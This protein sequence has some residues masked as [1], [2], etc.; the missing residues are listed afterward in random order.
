L[1]CYAPIKLA[2]IVLL[3]LIFG[4]LLIFPLVSNGEAFLQTGG[5]IEIHI[6]PGESQSFTWGLNSESDKVEVIKLRAEEAGRELL[7]FPETIVLQP[8]EWFTVIVTVS[9]PEDHP[10]DVLLQPR[11]YALLEGEKGEGAMA[12][13]IQM[14]NSPLIYIGN[15]VIEEPVVEEKPVETMEEPVVEE[16]QEEKAQQEATP[17][18]LESPEEQEE[19]GGCLIS[20]AT[21]GSELAPQVQMLREIRDNALLE[22]ESGTAFMSGF[23]SLY[24]SFSPTIADLERQSPIFKQVVKVTLTPLI[25]SL[26]ILNYVDMDSEAA[27]LGYGIS[28]ILLN[29]GMYFIAPAILITRLRR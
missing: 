28:L 8:G 3:F 1:G 29:V 27:V 6:N 26:S 25:T 12:I 4:I 20:T 9:I 19:G 16:K 10:N 24:Y 17:L 11:I 14:R 13:N 23:N 5:Q 7:T 22:T 15:P 18:I 21:F 2:R